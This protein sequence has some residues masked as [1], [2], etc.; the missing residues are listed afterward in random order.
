MSRMRCDTRIRTRR[1]D[2][3]IN[4]R[5]NMCFWAPKYLGV[6][7]PGRLNEATGALRVGD[8]ERVEAAAAESDENSVRM[9]SWR[10]LD[11]IGGTI[12]SLVRGSVRSL[13]GFGHSL[14][15][16]GAVEVGEGLVG[17]AEAACS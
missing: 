2:I 9:G 14:P 13:V 15:R 5:Q 12:S 8:T 1:R 11:T 4:N 10:E 16:E 3:C 17:S 6:G 7:Q